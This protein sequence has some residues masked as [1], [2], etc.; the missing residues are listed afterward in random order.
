MNK[1]I[2]LLLSIFLVLTLISFASA[3]DTVT[4]VTPAASTYVRG[5]YNFSAT[6]A[7]PQDVS[8]VT[9]RYNSSGDT[10]VTLCID[11]N[12]SAGATA[13]SCEKATTGYS[14]GTFSFYAYAYANASSTLLDNDDSATVVMDNTAP[15]VTF[16]IPTYYLDTGDHFTVSCTA[17]DSTAGVA[18]YSV[19]IT[20]DDG[21]FASYNSTSTIASHVFES[22]IFYA[23]GSYTANC[24]VYDSA[25]NL[26]SKLY[27]LAVS[28]E[29]GQ[30]IIT[31]EE[32]SILRKTWVWALAVVV[33]LTCVLLMLILSR[34][35]KHGK[36]K[37]R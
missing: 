33:L 23:P 18:N 20:R 5:T 37:G 17:T 27:T 16:T 12:E 29:D 15:T 14:D 11:I 13:F 25:S 34:K 3:A 28:S 30:V 7:T 10:Q 6:I 4:L 21:T 9:F 31:K 24:T 8:N 2:C 19:F 35:R 36:R 22:N 32:E 1:S 26:N